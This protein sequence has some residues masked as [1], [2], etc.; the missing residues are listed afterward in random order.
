MSLTK[1]LPPGP[2]ECSGCWQIGFWRKAS[3]GSFGKLQIQ[4]SYYGT[5]NVQRSVNKTLTCELRIDSIQVPIEGH[6]SALVTSHLQ[7]LSPTCLQISLPIIAPQ[8]MESID[9]SSWLYDLHIMSRSAA[10]SSSSPVRWSVKGISTW[11]PDGSAWKIPSTGNWW[12]T[13]ST[14]TKT[15]GLTA[16]RPR[17]SLLILVILRVSWL[18]CLHNLHAPTSFTV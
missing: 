5:K 15:P 3:R 10:E 6:V 2:L 14:S 17:L 13:P 7:T 18:S 11:V 9:D 4:G 8:S 16:L 1:A 12:W